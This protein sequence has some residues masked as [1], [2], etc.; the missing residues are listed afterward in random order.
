MSFQ[1]PIYTVLGQQVYLPGTYTSSTLAV[2]QG[3]NPYTG[4]PFSTLVIGSIMTDADVLDPNHTASIWLDASYD[5]G[6]TWEVAGG[7]PYN[8]QGGNYRKDGITPAA[9]SIIRDIPDKMADG[10]IV[11]A[12]AVR[13]RLDTCGNTLDVGLWLQFS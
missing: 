4:A 3:I 12:N 6:L 7:N 11:Q 10:A 2:T 8:W 9:P 5:G 1:G 13:V